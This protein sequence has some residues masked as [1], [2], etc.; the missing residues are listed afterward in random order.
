M[1]SWTLLRKVH[2]WTASSLWYDFPPPTL[3]LFL[4]VQLFILTIFNTE[5][6]TVKY[7]MCIR[8]SLF[9]S[10][11]MNI[12]FTKQPVYTHCILKTQRTHNHIV[13]AGTY[14][15]FLSIHPWHGFYCA[16]LW[17]PWKGKHRFAIYIQVFRQP[18]AFNGFTVK[19]GIP[20]NLQENSLPSG[21]WPFPS[22]K[23][24]KAKPRMSF[25]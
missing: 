1:L 13:F 6:H 10:L 3:S 17:Q 18:S 5:W 15:H 12:M 21:S 24:I 8:T 14:C 4:F 19:S 23:H 22:F 25:A 20:E 16:K 11:L 9:T 2:L 7:R